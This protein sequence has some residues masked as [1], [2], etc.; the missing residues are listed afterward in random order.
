M[1]V[2]TATKLW[3]LVKPIKR[4]RAWRKRR[5]MRSWIEE[6]GQPVDET[7]EDFNLPDEDASMD[8]QVVT[9]ILLGIVRHA[10]TA[11]GA[12]VYLSDDIVVQ[13]VSAAVALAGALW[14]AR[15]KIK[16]AKAG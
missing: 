11:S 16:A 7:L 13:V 4:I 8:Q 10:M 14:M 3:L 5:R 6:H 15:R 1:D 12:G 9:Q 2:L